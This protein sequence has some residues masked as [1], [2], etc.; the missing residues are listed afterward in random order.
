MS[1]ACATGL[2]D[3]L[4]RGVLSA[5]NC[6][7]R[8]F[9]EAGYVALTGQPQFQTALT[10]LLT[11]YIAVV[12][13]R[14]VF[15]SGG[16]RLTD[17]AGI[18]LKVGA[19]LTL[20]ASWSTFQTLV[21]DV[22]AKAPLDV[23]AVLAKPLQASGS[24]LAGDP[25]GGLQV[26]YDELAAGGRAFG[27]LAAPK[28]AATPVSPQAA[29]Q[30]GPEEN[31]RLADA[32]A[33]QALA[34]AATALFT[35]SVG[36]VAVSSIVIGVLSAIGP[37]F[38][39]MFL[40]QETRGLFAGWL[41]AMIAAGLA[42]MGAWILTVM[43]LA[44]LEPWLVAL[45]RQRIDGAFDDTTAMTTAAIVFVFSASQVALL[46]GVIV[47]AL[48]LRLP[49]RAPRSTETD[50]APA[51]GEAASSAV[52]ASSR[53]QRLSQTLQAM[54][55]APAGAQEVRRVGAEPA[56]LRRGVREAAAPLRLGEVYRRTGYREGRR[57]GLRG[58]R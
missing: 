22:A 40:F 2:D 29:I 34:S 19:I 48:G 38:I 46:G 17:A 21:F 24:A 20:A 47:I 10:L 44:V 54:Q 5:V 33:A 42:P 27:V 35:T 52:E 53:A 36:L 25:V 13:Y 26:A 58:A 55:S 8:D 32:A 50:R 15:A 56:P 18:A 51:P 12:G 57:A 9:A 1:A 23:A 49:Q 45:A 31:A 37:I 4:V 11:I 30:A 39:A 16:A 41:R 43:G 6:Q 14:L 28:A 7:T 3:G